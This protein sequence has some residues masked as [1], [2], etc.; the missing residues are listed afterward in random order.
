MR[1]RRTTLASAASFFARHSKY[2]SR[3]RTKLGRGARQGSE[4][5]VPSTLPHEC[6]R[7]GCRKAAGQACG[8]AICP[9]AARHCGERE[10]ENENEKET[11]R[12]THLP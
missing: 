6:A 7:S 10:N 5:E 12:R 8:R 11:Q 9:R 1:A 4:R 3:A 2:L